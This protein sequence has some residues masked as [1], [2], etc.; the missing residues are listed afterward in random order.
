VTRRISLALAIHNH[1]PVG[2][3]GWVFAEV[4]EQ[5]YFPLVEALERH[6]TIGLSLH[7]TGPL[8]EWLRAER[9][10]FIDR[11]RALVERDQVEVIG[12]GLYEPVLA[13]LPER[14][15]VAQLRRMAEE[16]EA[17]FGRRPAGAWLAERVWEPDLP[18]SLVA[19]GY[20][21]TILDDAHFRAAA[22]PEEALWGPY[23]T[24]DQGSLLSV[25]GT[26][27]GLRY[28]IPFR[29]VDEVVEYLR[30]HATEAGE[31][32]GMMGDDGEKFGA[33]P[34]TWEHCWGRGKWVERFFDAL[35]ANADWLTTVTPSAWLAAHRP[36]GR[37][38]V[39]TGSYA[40]MGEWALPPDES[41][42]YSAIL[43]RAQA[44][45][46][47]EAR[48]LRG[49]FWRN[50][51]VKYREINDLHKQMLRVSAKVDAMPA[52]RARELALDHLHR[53]QSNDC[54]WHGLF[55]GI[56]I[57]HMRLATH[58]HL[59]AAEDLADAAGGVAVA[60]RVV[61]LDLDGRDEV[62]LATDGEVVTVELDD[63]AGIGA[64]DV[65]ASRH[66]L[67][68]VMRRRPEAYHETLR[69]H[70]ARAASL[71]AS[72]TT[73][74]AGEA[75]GSAEGVTSIHELAHAKEANLSA[76][77]VY[78]WHERR[79]GLVRM[80]ASG[81]LPADPGAT[82]EL[83]RGDFVDG[84]FAV[85]ELAD[86]RV[87]VG[88]DGSVDGPGGPQAVRVEKTIR[89]GG[90]RR[91]PTLALEVAVENRSDRPLEGVLAV[92]W[93]TTMLGG[94]GNPSAWWDVDGART[95]HD[96]AGAASFLGAIAQGNDH[97]GV[98]VT[99][100]IEPR[101]EA[102]WAPIETVSNSE[103]GF[104]RVYQGSALLLGWPLRL[105]AGERCSV[106][107]AHAVSASRDRAAEELAADTAVA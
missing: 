21:W 93:P 58:E 2:N 48:W 103:S 59:I 33:W 25:F 27:Q 36:I 64:W 91:S 42:V 98:A 76:R 46:R 13:S 52:G 84:A 71:A 7:Y 73:E 6:P 32:V 53:G 19:G 51:Q 50:F 99:T 28:R 66:A 105:A 55:G 47:P 5:A 18:T 23:T 41:R 88:R 11:L 20:A 86:R 56:Y 22:I 95:G 63:G 39:P 74:A 77:L 75:P 57:S 54:Y 35:E 38:Y 83:E 10:A 90:D 69:A 80:L 17:T 24:D 4:F 26:E 12:G 85:V 30:E 92:D 78:D 31:R 100:T 79:A 60:A 67:G 87:V 72:G 68:A 45:R 107:V 29:E 16:L 106:L 94:G 40:E 43:H 96:V 3:F 8:L 1:Q 15:R 97:I 37:V 89:L 14:D 34:T 65:R 104:E 102:A 9:P 82:R 81:G 61:D 44:E 101:A 70:E 49:A 62:L